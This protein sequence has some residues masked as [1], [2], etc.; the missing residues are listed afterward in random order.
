MME[1]NNNNCPITGSGRALVVVDHFAT[2]RSVV[3]G[4][5]MD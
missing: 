2:Y 4:A 3:N 1:K 5:G